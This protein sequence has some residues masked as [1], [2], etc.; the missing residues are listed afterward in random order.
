MSDIGRLA[1]IFN[2]QVGDTG[3]AVRVSDR[4]SKAI[5]VVSGAGLPFEIAKIDGV[6]STS[7][8]FHIAKKGGSDGPYCL[9]GD[10]L[11]LQTPCS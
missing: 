3:Q 9:I 4:Q 11:P 5:S 8:T 2:R 6:A 7:Y 10:K 1:L